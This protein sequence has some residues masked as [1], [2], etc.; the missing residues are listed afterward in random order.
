MPDLCTRILKSPVALKERE[1]RLITEKS[2]G[3]PLFVE[4]ILV[5]LQAADAIKE[6]NGFI[7]TTRPLD[8][9]SI[10][11]DL[12]ELVLSTIASAFL[13]ITDARQAL[14][15]ASVKGMSLNDGAVDSVAPLPAS[16]AIF[17]EVQR[18]FALVT[19]T[20]SD[21][22]LSDLWR[23]RHPEHQRLAYE[24]AGTRVSGMHLRLAEHLSRL[25][26]ADP[27]ELFYHYTRFGMRSNSSNYPAMH[28]GAARYPRLCSTRTEPGDTW[29]S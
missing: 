27:I 28:G 10:D 22:H 24:H 6:V 23:F 9:V 20:D 2:G 4:S 5:A 14:E 3:L 26:H 17:A 21:T 13:A 18:R 11:N 12:R 7:R 16:H 1:V 8:A 19:Q 29:T 25:P 15:V